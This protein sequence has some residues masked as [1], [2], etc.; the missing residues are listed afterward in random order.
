[1]YNILTFNT[2]GDQRVRKNFSITLDLCVKIFTHISLAFSAK[3][4]KIN[5]STKNKNHSTFQSASKVEKLHLM[6]LTP[7]TSTF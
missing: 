2:K 5:S 7:L 4:N 3:N 6:F 1:M